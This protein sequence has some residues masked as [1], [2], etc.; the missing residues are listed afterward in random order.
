MRRK[1]FTKDTWRDRK[2]IKLD[3]Y[4]KILEKNLEIPPDVY[5]MI[6]GFDGSMSTWFKLCSV[7]SR[8]RRVLLEPYVMSAVEFKTRIDARKEQK[9]KKPPS[10]LIPITKL[11]VELLMPSLH[12]FQKR[13]VVADQLL[14]FENLEKLILRFK[15]DVKFNSKLGEPL[16]YFLQFI[17]YSK[18]NILVLDHLHIGIMNNNDFNRAYTIDNSPNGEID[19]TRAKIEH[20]EM[21]NVVFYTDVFYE[22]RQYTPLKPLF[23][24]PSTMKSIFFNLAAIHMELHIEFINQRTGYTLPIQ[25]QPILSCD[26]IEIIT[27]QRFTHEFRAYE[28]IHQYGHCAHLLLTNVV[29]KFDTKH[30]ITIKRLEFVDSIIMNIPH[31]VYIEEIICNNVRRFDT[32]ST[33]YAIEELISSV[34]LYG[35]R[36]LKKFVYYHDIFSNEFLNEMKKSEIQCI[37]RPLPLSLTEEEHRD[38]SIDPMLLETNISKKTN[39]ILEKLDL[40]D[41]KLEKYE[42]KEDELM[43]EV[44]LF[45]ILGEWEKE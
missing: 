5:S 24:L 19:L 28:Y 12:D 39:R 8:I 31:N 14:F 34:R 11:D 43:R 10:I 17:R 44:P 20:L 3:E 9:D 45:D 32:R 18:L 2:I 6:V 36:Q 7:D 27:E 38:L 30:P 15:Y 37:E 16:L 42:Q 13:R 4:F 40:Y 41:Y 33:E 26:E 1:R 21:D 22:D 25:N 35:K 23:I 29:L